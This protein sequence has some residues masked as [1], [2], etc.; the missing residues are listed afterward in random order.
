MILDIIK[1]YKH[2]EKMSP[3]IA[4]AL[5]IAAQTDFE[6][7]Q[8]G[9][10]E[11]DGDKLFYIVQ[12][13]KTKS[14][15]DKIEAHRKYIDIQLMVKGE[16]RIGYAPANG[17]KQAVE[18]DGEKEVEFFQVPKNI[19]FLNMTKGYFAIFCP[20][21]AHMPGCQINELGDVIKVVFKVKV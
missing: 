14:S 6:K 13:Y 2:Y 15:A 9:K 21:D 16:E 4:K 19:T 20:S 3:L 8:D 11:V 10:Y 17:L 7:L 5:Q 18:Y 1:N 12:R